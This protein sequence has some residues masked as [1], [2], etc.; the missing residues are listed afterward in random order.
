MSELSAA[1]RVAN[2]NV[3]GIV[4]RLVADGSVLRVP[5]AGDKRATLVLL[6]KKGRDEFATMAATHRQW[7]NQIFERVSPEL[8]EQIVAAMDLVS[9]SPALAKEGK[10]A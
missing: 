1:L 3:T 5:V 2:G 8:S 9:A 7:V 10:P 4:E 6:T